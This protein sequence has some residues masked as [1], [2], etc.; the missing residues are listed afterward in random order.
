MYEARQNK[1]KVSRRID[2]GEVRHRKVC[3]KH[4]STIQQCPKI[5]TTVNHTTTHNSIRGEKMMNK[6]L[7]TISAQ[8]AFDDSAN[9]KVIKLTQQN[10]VK[11]N[12]VKP[13]YS[14]LK[15]SAEK[16]NKN[17]IQEKEPTK[18]LS[19]IGD[20]SKWDT[21]RPIDQQM[22]TALEE[23]EIRWRSMP[24]LEE[25]PPLSDVI[26]YLASKNRYYS[27]EL[28]LPYLDFAI[29]QG[30]LQS[31]YR[32]TKA[33]GLNKSRHDEGKP[34]NDFVFTRQL[35][36]HRSNLTIGKGQV[37]SSGNAMIIMRPTIFED[38]GQMAFFKTFDGAHKANIL[39]PKKMKGKHIK[40]LSDSIA[41]SN[42]MVL[43]ANQEQGIRGNIDLKHIAAIIIKSTKGKEKNDKIQFVEHLKKTLISSQLPPK[44]I[45]DQIT[46]I[47]NKEQQEEAYNKWINGSGKRSLYDVLK[48]GLN[49]N[50]QSNQMEIEPENIIF[51]LSKETER[52]KIVSMLRNLYHSSAPI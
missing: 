27:H 22:K 3:L 49:K 1:E 17:K 34:Q 23:F 42:D 21:S 24:D 16:K 37:G 51:A 11:P 28:P 26:K 6:R 41:K 5:F 19:G 50:L 31:G 35:P 29:A 30:G 38:P 7:I 48:E 39:P 33:L 8:D 36:T 14:V 12:I 18:S 25:E 20:I 10:I 46:I 2:T 15:N 4:T 47:E 52:Y 45:R 44:D 13:S 40:T 9:R 43:L 32:A